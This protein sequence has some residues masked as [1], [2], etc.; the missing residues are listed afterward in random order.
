MLE[1]FRRPIFLIGIITLIAGLDIAI[2]LSKLPRLIGILF[3][4]A[5]LLLIYLDWKRNKVSF[6]I[7]WRKKEKRKPEPR[8]SEKLITKLTFNKKL[9]QYFPIVG[10]AIIIFVIWL[11]L[12]I[13]QSGF[14][15][16]DSVVIAFGVILVIYPYLFE[17]Y[18]IEMDFIL[19]F[20][21]FLIFILIFPL[22]LSVMLTGSRTGLESQGGLVTIF[23]SLP[24]A[25]ILS[26]LGIENTVNGPILN[27]EMQNGAIGSIGIAASCAGIYSLGIFLAAYIAFV[28]SEFSKFNRRIGYLLIL[29][30]IATYLANLLRM[31]III[32]AG[33]YNGIGDPRNPEPFTL[34]WM[35]EY[36]GEII[37]ICW[38]ALFWWLAFYYLMGDEQ[39]DRSE[40]KQ[41]V[42]EGNRKEYDQLT[43]ES[44]S[45]IAK[46]EKKE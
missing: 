25:G 3:I 40:E 12:V 20:F 44:Q 39:K 42:V 30:V 15:S 41:L 28:L 36:A 27:F 45:S 38:A 22:W 17:K 4:F 21:A 29:G 2:L 18:R 11:N 1:L 23:L 32:L 26:L 14:G 8:L 46:I 16:F 5:G 31:T 6:S 33:Y 34:V 37:F 10:I 9:I 35:H 24:L 13:S 19:L 43:N 7:S